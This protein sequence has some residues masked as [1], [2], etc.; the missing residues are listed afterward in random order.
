TYPFSSALTELATSATERAARRVD[1][2]EASASPDRRADLFFFVVAGFLVVLA[3]DFLTLD[4]A[5]VFT[6]TGTPFAAFLAVDFFAVGFFAVDFLAAGFRAE[7]AA[8]FFLAAEAFRV[9]VFL[10]D[11]LAVVEGRLLAEPVARLETVFFFFFFAVLPA[12]FFDGRAADRRPADFFVPAEVFFL[13]ELF[14]L[15]VAREP[16]REVLVELREEVFFRTAVFLATASFRRRGP[17]AKA[18][19][20]LAC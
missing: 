3:V 17:L 13:V 7:P 12:D 4:F 9:A 15:E 11:R 10:V 16:A 8:V 19:R 20:R 6:S 5:A 18:S 14:F 2:D 1:R